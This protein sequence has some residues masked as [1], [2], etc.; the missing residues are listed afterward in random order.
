MKHKLIKLLLFGFVIL[1]SV[2][3]QADSGNNIKLKGHWLG[4]LFDNSS[5]ARAFVELSVT[6][7]NDN[8]VTGT[9]VYT[10][11]PHSSLLFNDY[12]DKNVHLTGSFV[13][14]NDGRHKIKLHGNHATYTEDVEAVLMGTSKN[15]RPTS[16]IFNVKIPHTPIIGHNYRFIGGLE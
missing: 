1:V 5:H 6:V 8:R 11:F 10:V 15:M 16:V 14:Y 13:T 3:S 9:I 12:H 2:T 7:N 4:E